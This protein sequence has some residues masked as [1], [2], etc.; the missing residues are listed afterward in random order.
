[1]AKIVCSKCG[2]TG[3]SKCPYCRTIFPDSGYEAMLSYLLK[4]PHPDK[5]DKGKP[6]SFKVHLMWLRHHEED[7]RLYT[8]A[9]MIR[10]L[11]NIL[12]KLDK[13]G[14]LEAYSCIHDWIFAPGAESSIGCGHRNREIKR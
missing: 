10:E 5:N 4:L 7:S 14:E 2:A 1:M 3:D 12:K 11:Y 9:E 13:R 6:V 8:D